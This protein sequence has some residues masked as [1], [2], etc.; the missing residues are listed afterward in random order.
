MSQANQIGRLER[1]ARSTGRR[2]AL[3]RAVAAA[4]AWLPLPIAYTALVLGAAKLVPLDAAQA[5]PW[6]WGALVPALV[7]V[8]AA[9]RAALRRRSPYEGALALDRHHGLDDRIANALAFSRVPESERSPLMQAAIADA[10]ERAPK[11]E[12]RRAAR[13]RLPVELAYSAGLFAAL[14]GLAALEVRQLRVVPPNVVRTQAALLSADDVELFRE[15]GQELAKASDDPQVSAAARRFNQL[16]EDIAAHRMDRREVFERLG[17][18][19]RE[20]AESS[21]LDKEA[22]DDGLKELARELE[23]SGLTKPAAQALSEKRLADAEQALR[24]L[25]E[26]LKKKQNVPTKAELDKLRSALQKASSAS[27]EHQ[28]AIEQR[29]KE[30]EEE[31]QSLLKKKQQ[32]GDKSAKT[33]Q[34]L[35]ENKRKL[36][37]LGRDKQRAERSQQ[38]LSELDKQLQD[39]ARQLMQDMQGAGKSLESAAEDV[40]RM[41]KQQLNDEQKKEMLKR[42]QEL[43][44]VLRQQ[45]KGGKEQMDRMQRFGERARGGGKQPGQNGKPGG[46][47]QPGQ[48]RLSRGAGD[49]PS[50]DVPMPGEGQGNGP[51]KDTEAPGQGDGAGRGYGSGH[52]ENLAGDPTK[53]EGKTQDVTAAGVDSGQGAASAEVIYGAAE[54]GFVGRGYQKVF[55]DYETVAEQVMTQDEI[56]PGYRFYVRRYF[57]L[58]RPRD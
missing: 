33:D 35:A 54:R 40:N 51:G 56:P 52:N 30:L 23:K 48:L 14:L 44:E 39:A 42:L 6:L 19:E 45:G 34:K 27:S 37:R 1:A 5:R 11:L 3:S 46:G 20:L 7:V 21:Q 38:K 57:Q 17:S 12:P 31:Q 9:L 24:E 41:G 15:I 29:R 8:S 10:A 53:L 36:E 32:E 2:L 55:T 26:R 4:A 43:R 49:G 13:I 22:L 58:I 16:V 18:L 50:I 25:A 47:K 28:T